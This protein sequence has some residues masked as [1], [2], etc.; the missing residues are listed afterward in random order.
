MAA[1]GVGTQVS[2]ARS[3]RRGGLFGLRSWR[4]AA[5]GAASIAAFFL[6]WYVA[7]E[8]TNSRHPGLVATPWHVFTTL[9]DLTT[10]PFAGRVLPL[11]VLS[12]LGRWG[13][14]FGFAVLIGVPLGILFG[15]V[16]IVREAVAP[17]FEFVRYIPPFA[18]IPLDILWLGTGE[19]AQA[20]IVFIAAFPAVV[21]STQVGAAG[22]DPALLRASTNLGAGRVRRLTQVITP[23]ALPAILSGI[24]IS[25]SNGWM[26]LIAAE[27]I[28]G[29]V[30]VGF[31]I[32]QGQA[33]G[34]ISIVMA[35]MVAIAITAALLDL[36]VLSVGK[37][38][39][40]WRTSVGS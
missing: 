14:G 22:V 12:S 17:L 8:V 29:R 32:G 11:H 5:W 13:P 23:V 38:L 6:L 9:T 26:G 34:D 2:L 7:A 28:G 10:E 30:G 31:L 3:S 19:R 35:G 21:I 18:W 33:N 25:A 20:L 40:R 39:T 37:R 24:R 36:I 16:R 1:E 27:L 4:D 15:A